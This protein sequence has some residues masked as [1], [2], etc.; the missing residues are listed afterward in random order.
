MRK[1]HARVDRWQPR[2]GQ[3]VNPG[4][5]HPGQGRGRP[6]ALREPAGDPPRRRPV[7]QRNEGRRAQCRH[8]ASSHQGLR[9]GIRCVLLPCRDAV[10]GQVFLHRL[11]PEKWSLISGPQIAAAAARPAQSIP[12]QRKPARQRVTPLLRP[13][14]CRSS[15]SHR[16]CWHRSKPGRNFTPRTALP[17]RAQRFLV[18]RP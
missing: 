9:Q 17:T 10:V 13:G 7:D 14:R 4:P 11:R 1:A 6:E 12:G 16:G 5:E 18:T 3:T 15:T 2:A 8:Q